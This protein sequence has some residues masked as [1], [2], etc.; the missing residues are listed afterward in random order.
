MPDDLWNMVQ[1]CFQYVPSERPDAHMMA[2]MI[3]GIAQSH[4]RYT[5]VGSGTATH[6]LS[7][8]GSP[9]PLF[10][11][12]I[13]D[14]VLTPSSS[15]ATTSQI[16]SSATQFDESYGTV[17]F[18]PVEAEDPEAFFS[19]LFKNLSRTIPKGGLIEPLSIQR[20]RDHLL[21]RFRT[22]LEANN[23]AMSWMVHRFGPHLQLTAEVLDD[24]V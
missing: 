14:Q 13:N 20:G 10:V 18:G 22:L 2:S 21:L 15:H 3:G 16:A 12:S 19:S 1:Q 7:T 9:L 11:E 5:S 24:E 6:S 8:S 23:F 4:D 17:L